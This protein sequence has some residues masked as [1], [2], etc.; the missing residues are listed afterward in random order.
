M[1]LFVKRGFLLL[2]LVLLLVFSTSIIAV[3][4]E[5]KEEAE[6]TGCSY[7]WN[8]GETYGREGFLGT[9]TTKSPYCV[10]TETFD[11]CTQNEFLDRR[12]RCERIRC[13]NDDCDSAKVDK[14]EGK[15]CSVF[16]FGCRDMTPTDVISYYGTNPLNLLS[17]SLPHVFYITKGGTNPHEGCEYGCS[18][19]KCLPPL[20]SELEE[21][22]VTCGFIDSSSEQICQVTTN[23]I[24]YED[25]EIYSCR[26]KVENGINSC[27]IK[28]PIPSKV[29]N[30]YQSDIENFLS[31]YSTCG[32]DIEDIDPD[33]EDGIIYYFTNC[34]NI[35]LERN[36]CV[37]Y[38]YVDEDRNKLSTPVQE[39]IEC[40]STIRRN[41][42]ISDFLCD[43][44]TCKECKTGSKTG[45]ILGI[46]AEKENSKFY[47]NSCLVHPSQHSYF[48]GHTCIYGGEGASA[49]FNG[50]HLRTRFYCPE[51]G[52]VLK[53]PVKTGEYC[54][55]NPQCESEHF[56]IDN[57]CVRDA[58]LKYIIKNFDRILKGWTQ[59]VEEGTD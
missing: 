41:S 39:E 59:I 8:T 37:A 42:R 55:S 1:K 20:E 54:E 28:I 18:N 6:I 17:L 32:G 4:D 2:N 3:S 7:D 53:S 44:N 11:Y 40:I 16:D 15:D 24:K 33:E 56:C 45:G 29:K 19:G 35:N 51:E 49:L 23:L 12:I 38:R 58:S 13:L 52:G 57:E 21:I 10:Q 47:E 34:E 25:N 26:S 27:S 9:F 48:D 46:P 14:C 43:G 5:V 36:N 22:E 31:V 50:D 30:S